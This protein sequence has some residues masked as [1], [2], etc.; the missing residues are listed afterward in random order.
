MSIVKRTRRNADDVRADAMAEARRLLLSDGPNAVTLKAV[1]APL[2]M[3]HANL[4][5]HFGSAAGMQAALVEE[6][7]GRTRESVR[8]AIAEIRAGRL[9][10][11]ALVDLVFDNFEMAG[12]GKLVG[13]LILSGE[14]ARLAPMLQGIHDLVDAIEADVPEP[15]P[16]TRSHITTATLLLVLSA[17][18]DSLAGSELHRAV[19]REREAARDAL[20]D[21]IAGMMPAPS[22]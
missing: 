19:G 9:R 6:M 5:H 14:G 4:I 16:Q 10:P 8:A 7:L 22:A 20:A 1:A 3:T 15:Q 12:T 13:W 11:R 18:G 2:G 21:L 17:I